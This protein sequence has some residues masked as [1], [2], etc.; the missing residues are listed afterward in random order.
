MPQKRMIEE[1]V[2]K[3]GG[4][5]IYSVTQEA[6]GAPSPGLGAVLRRPQWLCMGFCASKLHF[7]K[8]VTYTKIERLRKT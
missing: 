6:G 2:S 3:A 1:P 5:S 8:D 7:L 4:L